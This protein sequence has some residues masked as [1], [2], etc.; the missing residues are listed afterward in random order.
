MNWYLFILGSSVVKKMLM[1]V[2]GMGLIG[3]L[4]VHLLGNAMAFAGAEA[5][6]GY[7]AGSVS[8]R[9]I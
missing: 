3:F 7:V 8:S 9:P 4:S 6:N 2:T 1:A 5:F